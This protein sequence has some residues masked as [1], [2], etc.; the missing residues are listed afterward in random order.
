MDLHLIVAADC[1]NLR[2]RIQKEIS[3]L[4]HE[5]E[6]VAGIGDLYHR[7]QETCFNGLLIDLPTSIRAE[8]SEKVLLY[9]LQQFFPILRI[10]W[11]EKHQQLRCQRYGGLAGSNLSV[12]SFIDLHCQSF[13]ARRIRKEKRLALHLNALLCCHPEFPDGMVER[14]STLNVSPSGCALLTTQ[15]WQNLERIWIKIL[16]LDDQTPMEVE[17]R[18]R[19]LWG[20]P[21]VLP[22]IGVKFIV[23]TDNQKRQLQTP[24]QICRP[25]PEKP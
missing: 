21:R 23:L 6:A 2:A 5:C 13:P 10:K 3:S 17:I 22:S 18:W 20:T 25:T 1:E 24:G 12:E 16:E 15:D 11:D 9:E 14:S 4:G 8:N 7:L 19:T